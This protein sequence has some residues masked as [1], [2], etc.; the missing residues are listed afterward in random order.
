MNLLESNRSS[1]WHLIQHCLKA[2]CWIYLT[3][4]RRHRGTY[5][6]HHIKNRH[7][8][9]HLDHWLAFEVLF[10]FFNQWRYLLTVNLHICIEGQVLTCYWGLTCPLSFFWWI[11]ILRYS[12]FKKKLSG[13][14]IHFL[15]CSTYAYWRNVYLNE[16]SFLLDT[17]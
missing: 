6:S 8:Q 3:L 16:E 1:K 14:E 13:K 15:L 7:V 12:H 5:P 4:S 11:Y 9:F 2:F 17:T 10:N